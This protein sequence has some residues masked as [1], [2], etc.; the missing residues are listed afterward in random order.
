MNTY[1]DKNL[2]HSDARFIK[3][4][5]FVNKEQLFEKAAHI[6]TGKKNR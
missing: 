2:V 1:K 4:L 6:F 3:L 5:F